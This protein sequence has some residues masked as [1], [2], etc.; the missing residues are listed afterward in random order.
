MNQRNERLLAQRL[1]LGTWYMG[2]H[3]TER[4]SEV[5]ALRAGIEMGITVVDTAEMYANGGAEEVTGEAIAGQREQIYLVSK[6]LPSNASRKGTI[7]AC[8]RSLRRL[9]TEYLD[10]Y[11]LHWQGSHP[12]AETVEAFEALRTRGLIREWG[13]S[14][15][16]L[17]DL[18]EVVNLEE[19]GVPVGENCVVNQVYY[20]LGARG[21][22]FDLLPWQRKNNIATMAYCPLD[23]GRLATDT[24]LQS[25]ADKHRIGETRATCAQI[26]LAWL[27]TRSD[28]LPIPKSASVA[29]TIENVQARE[30][31]LDA[32][33]LALLDQLFPPPTRKIHLEM[34]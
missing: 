23:Q 28:V 12:L 6:A 3:A 22:E 10:L 16:D 8:E 11:L 9:K 1:G 15:F 13:V 5:A 29:R 32:D 33:D 25:I 26:A 24:R 7:S 4:A 34:V 18:Q 27:M 2:T 21:I 19:N 30:L 31:V 17:S 20:S 14:N